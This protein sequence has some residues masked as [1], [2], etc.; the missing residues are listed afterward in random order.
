MLE[1]CQQRNIVRFAAV[2]VLLMS[3]CGVAFANG[4]V[5]GPFNEHYYQLIHVD[6]GVTWEEAHDLAAAQSAEGLTGYLA[7]ITTLEE[8]TFIST[9]IPQ[10][11]LQTTWLGATDDRFKG[12]FQWH[13]GESDGYGVGI[14][15]MYASWSAGQP[16]GGAA[17]NCL[18][19]NG[20]FASWSDEEC[21]RTLGYVLV[22]YS[23]P[24]LATTYCGGSSGV[25][26][27]PDIA[28]YA[29]VPEIGIIADR[30]C[31]NLTQATLFD[32]Q[33]VPLVSVPVYL[34]ETAS[35]S[36]AFPVFA[37]IAVS[38]DF[39]ITM[40]QDIL[41]VEG[42]IIAGGGGCG[43]PVSQFQEHRLERIELL[44][45]D[46]TRVEYDPASQMR[47]VYNDYT[48]NFYGPAPS[49]IE[50]DIDFKPGNRRNV[51]NPR[52]RGGV[53]V[54]ILSDGGFD[55]LQV[56]P[57]T[58]ALGLGAANPIRFR[59]K[60][61]NRDRMPDLMMRF[62]TPRIGI[63]CET[64]TLELVGETYSSEQVVGTDTIKTRGCAA[65]R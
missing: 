16:D 40:S 3:F 57:G 13:N 62:R 34:N 65:R 32:D 42:N 20:A 31:D 39:C 30:D 55:A 6:P 58:V 23:A 4:E 54:A 63:D 29:I 21:G 15:G 47:T 25:A 11:A 64:T 44:I 49:R 56:D 37:N 12:F 60:D 50:V 17:E 45:G 24:I 5:V 43:S 18:A 35:S 19:S 10:I 22:E 28:A 59:V 52:S 1:P 33:L 2:A 27:V 53:W 46:E 51:I 9:S 8:H 61:V 26:P 36:T 7:T 38:G 14:A 48:V 41:D